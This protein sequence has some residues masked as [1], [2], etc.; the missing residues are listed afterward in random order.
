MM[1]T[2]ALSSDWNTRL[3]LPLV[4]AKPIPETVS[5]LMSESVE[6]PNTL[7]LWVVEVAVLMRVP[8]SVGWRVLSRYTGI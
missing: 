1:F 4:P 6:T 7:S 5:I 8:L 3:A 2:P